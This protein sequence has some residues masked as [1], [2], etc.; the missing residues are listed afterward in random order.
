M[1][2]RLAAGASRIRTRGPTW[3]NRAKRNILGLNSAR[4]YGL[5]GLATRPA[6]TRGSPYKQGDLADYASYMQPGSTIDDVLVLVQRRPAQDFTRI[7]AA[8]TA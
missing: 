4:L 6:G 8:R 5:Q 7:A 2:R 1:F 3:P